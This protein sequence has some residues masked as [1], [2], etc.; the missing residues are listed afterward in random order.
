MSGT[1]YLPI[2]C[3][4]WYEAFAFCA[5]D[6]GRLPTEAEWN[7]AAAGGSQQR[8]YPWSQPPTNTEIDA[9]YA[10]YNC[11][12]TGGTDEECFYSDIRPVGSRSP[13]GDGLW[14]QADLAGS[15][16]EWT[17]DV[18]GTYP[19]ECYDCVNTVGSPAQVVR[20]GCWNSTEGKLRAAFRSFSYP[21]A[22]SRSPE[23]RYM[24]TGFRC[25][26]AS[27]P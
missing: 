5:W 11:Q 12:G 10:V 20:G 21:S 26:R 16:F 23:F 3:V 8:Y 25:A 18:E 1:S 15:M 17:L 14:G 22:S 4:R 19:I 7:Y 2:N 27:A 24:D 13:K 6:G 9:S